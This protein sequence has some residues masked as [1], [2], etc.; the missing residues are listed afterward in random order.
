M[1]TIR[2]IFPC[3]SQPQ[4]LTCGLT[5]ILCEDASL[6]A[7]ADVAKC[8]ASQTHWYTSEHQFEELT[9]CVYD[10]YPADKYE[11]DDNYQNPVYLAVVT[12]NDTHNVYIDTD[13]YPAQAD[14]L[15]QAETMAQ[16]LAEHEYAFNYHRDHGAQAR[17]LLGDSHHVRREAVR[18]TRLARTFA[19]QGM[20]SDTDRLAHKELLADAMRAFESATHLR[21][22]LRAF[23][24][25]HHVDFGEAAAAWRDGWTSHH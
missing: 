5:G 14:A 6:L 24:E 3:A 4:T 1:T 11:D 8:A 21:K 16:W 17:D 18:L 23:F 12:S 20:R 7:G 19:A 10:F 13:L 9:G 15:S 25:E 22:R 2:D